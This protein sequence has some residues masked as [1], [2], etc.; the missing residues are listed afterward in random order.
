M[1]RFLNSIWYQKNHPVSL[2]LTPLS[3]VF[4]L[5]ISVKAFLYRAGFL[6]TK[7]VGCPVIVVG[8]IA[9]GG[10]GKT[11]LVVWL[12]NQLLVAGYRPGIIARGYGGA[13]RTW[14]QQVRR[15]SDPTAVGEEAVLLARSVACPVAVGPD[16]VAAA[17]ALRIYNNCNVIISDDGLQHLRLR[18]CIEIGVVDGIRRNGNGRCLPAGPLRER[19]GRL[20]K[21]DIIVANQGAQ[22]GEFDMA[23]GPIRLVSLFDRKI[24]RPITQFAGETVHAV[25]GIGHPER[26][27]QTLTRCGIE[28]IEHVFDDHHRFVNSDFDFDDDF[29]VLMT[30]K[31]AI[32]CERFARGGFWFLQVETILSKVVVDKV[33]ELLKER[34]DG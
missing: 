21:V 31:D 6:R 28:I 17:Q 26:F 24:E 5:G 25:C 27:F 10:T 23:L 2:F 12:A 16:R 8:N 4:V 13:A 1:H 15:D 22:R 9:V 18:R 14:P 33:F 7:S 20:K 32:K 34:S 30:E 19:V 11:P 3:W 29:P